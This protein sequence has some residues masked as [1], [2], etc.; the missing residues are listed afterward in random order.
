MDVYTHL[1]KYKINKED[2]THPWKKRQ[3]DCNNFETTNPSSSLLCRFNAKV[4]TASIYW[5]CTFS[6]S[7][8]GRGVYLN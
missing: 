2:K 1:N 4:V 8:N 5:A 7:G 6:V 3:E